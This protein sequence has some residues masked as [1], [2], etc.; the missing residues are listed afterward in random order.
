M[1]KGLAVLLAVVVAGAA[2]TA[3]LSVFIVSETQQALVLRFGEPVR[4]ENA[5]S[6]DEATRS[7]GLKFKLPWENVVVMDRRNLDFDSPPNEI[8]DVDQQLLIVDSF[9]RF[10]I[11]DPLRFYQAVGNERVARTR[12]EPYLDAALR[13]VLGGVSSDDIISGQRARLMVA[14]QNEVNRQTTESGLGIEIIDVR[15]KRADLPPQI[16][17]R[18]YV[19]METQRHQ[20][21]ALIRAEGEERGL[22][23]RA[24]ADRQVRVI[25]AEA[26]E[27]SERVRGAGDALRNE[28]YAAAYGRD[29]EFFAFYRSMLAYE[30][31]IG[32]GTTMV[33]S[34]NS[35]FF[36]YFQSQHGDH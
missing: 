3:Y 26:N 30:A 4:V 15:L 22:S 17:D 10:R 1:L 31:A 27:Q 19:R 20:A 23:I 18:V 6:E 29:P 21:A 28:I 5:W 7:P 33:L 35:E 13:R 34:P 12:L 16:A 25:Q 36:E 32:S 8:F 2:F 11:S 9:V 24:N 14:I